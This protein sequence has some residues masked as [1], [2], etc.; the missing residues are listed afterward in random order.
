MSHATGYERCDIIADRY[1][2]GSL[3]EGTRN[4]RG[5]DGSTLKFIGDNQFPSDFKDFLSNS[6]NKDKLSEF[7]AQELINIHQSSASTVTMVAT[8]KTSILTTDTDLLHQQDI[9]ECTAE[10]ADPRI[11]RHSINLAGYGFETVIIRTVD[12]D[13][14][15]LSL[16]YVQNMM[17]HGAKNVYTQLLKNSGTEN[18]I[19]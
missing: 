11:I 1:F 16:S 4:K 2:E 9:S 15:V 19:L 13:D 18:L 12:S 8:Y 5:N 7:L 6:Q 17:E 10:E 14:V 3:K